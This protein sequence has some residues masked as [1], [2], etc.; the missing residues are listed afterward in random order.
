MAHN[1]QIER[2]IA[3]LKAQNSPNIA[4]TAREFRIERSTL[5]KPFRGKATSLDEVVSN[6]KKELS[7]AQEAVLITHIN[8]RSDRGLPP[9]PRVV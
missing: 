8:K 3:H 5:S 4:A 9:T 1:P 7:T 6:T 2:A